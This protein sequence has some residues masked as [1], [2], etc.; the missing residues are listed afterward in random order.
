MVSILL[1]IIINLELIILL[2]SD[3]SFVYKLAANIGVIRN[4]VQFLKSLNLQLQFIAIKVISA[5]S[6]YRKISFN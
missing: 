2:P 4:L 1:F 6:S 5:L 3:N